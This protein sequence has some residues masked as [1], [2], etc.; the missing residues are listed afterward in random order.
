VFTGASVVATGNHSS[1]GWNNPA[2]TGDYNLL[3]NDADEI[4]EGFQ[5]TITG[6]LP[7]R[8]L[9]YTYSVCPVPGF[10][11]QADITVPGASSAETVRV[12]GLM[13]GNSFQLGVTHTVHDIT[14]T[15]GTL[16]I[17]AVGVWPTAFLNG[18]QIV[19]VP[20]PGTLLACAL[21]LA[22]TAI[23]RRREG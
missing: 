18:F 6:L 13:P 20:E 4:G 22:G 10:A 8:Y 11:G 14:L 1:G 17:Q 3:L 23:K 5:Y 9:V 7:G 16:Q 2:N 12:Q 15:G 19:P 21:G